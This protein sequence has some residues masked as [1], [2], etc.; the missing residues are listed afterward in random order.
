MPVKKNLIILL[1]IG[2]L[3]LFSAEKQGVRRGYTNPYEANISK[4][5]PS[6]EN[7]LGQ[8]K[9][10]YASCEKVL[11]QLPQNTQSL[12]VI[13]CWKNMVHALKALNQ[14]EKL[15]PLRGKFLSRF[16]RNVPFLAGLDIEAIAP[17]GY[18]QDHRFYRGE[19]EK[20]YLPIF[21]KLKEDRKL[22]L[23]YMTDPYTLQAAENAA[24][25]T[26]KRLYFI[27]LRKILLIGNEPLT[28]YEVQCLSKCS[29][30][31]RNEPLNRAALRINIPRGSN[32]YPDYPKHNL[33]TVLLRIFADDPGYTF[34]ELR[35]FRL[36]D[37]GYGWMPDLTEASHL[38]P[39][40]WGCEATQFLGRIRKDR[41][42]IPESRQ[43]SLRLGNH[44]AAR[45]KL[46][47]EGKSTW[48]D[49]DAFLACAAGRIG[50]TT[51]VI[52]MYPVRKKLSPF[53]NIMIARALPETTEEYRT[54]CSELRTLQPKDAKSMA[55]Y[56]TFL[57]E[58]MPNDP[59]IPDLQKAVRRTPFSLW[60]ARALYGEKVL[61]SSRKMP[62]G[63]M[64]DADPANGQ[65]KLTV[66]K[67]LH[68]LRIGL[69]GTMPVPHCGF[70]T[71]DHDT[72]AIHREAG[73][74]RE[75]LLFC[76]LP[77]GQYMIRLPAFKKGTITAECYNF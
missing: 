44:L 64:I 16:P 25:P 47:R 45:Y 51:A 48:N 63:L 58:K 33:H 75:Y 41:A 59:R 56:L 7:L 65:L 14:Y 10:A 77:A 57:R 13:S 55:A 39:T 11:K 28:H 19:P 27:N 1:C 53:A 61:P 32:I 37:A 73:K 62:A 24:D 69:P 15:E 38:L 40:A 3:P 72:Q 31:L 54:I 60:K 68:Y 35:R 66:K 22:L 26:L 71:F 36:P 5:S 42:A 49:N 52:R 21:P 23:R 9:K 20:P 4:F 18:W 74:D 67:E 76:R 6:K 43:T 70:R 34:R 2:L 17:F 8:Y 46:V 50:N 30:I 29:R 12:Q